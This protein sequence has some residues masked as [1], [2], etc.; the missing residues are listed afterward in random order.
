MEAWNKKSGLWGVRLRSRLAPHEAEVLTS[1]VTAL[2]DLLVQRLDS[3]PRDELTDLT[4]MRPAHSTTP[5]HPILARLLP[6]FHLPEDLDAEPGGLPENANSTLRSLH[7]PEIIDAKREALTRMLRT[8]PRR[9]G[10]VVLAP[11]DAEAWLAAV[12]D[13]RLAL[14]TMLGVD[15]TEEDGSLEEFEDEYSADPEARRR[16]SEREAYHWLTFLQDSLCQAI[17]D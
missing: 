16:A 13:L 14:G 7:E 1:L 10:A 5:K 4:G 17:F 2:L 11:E 9:G 6:E 8:I 15:G 3:A 12:N